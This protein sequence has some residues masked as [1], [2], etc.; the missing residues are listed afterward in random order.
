[1]ADRFEIRKLGLEHL[2]WA[3]AIISHS[4]IFHSPAWAEIY[5]ENKTERLYQTFAAAEYLV[6]HQIESGWSYGVFDREY[7]FKR[8]ASINDAAGGALYWDES[9]KTATGAQLLEQMDFPLVSIALALDAANPLDHTLLTSMEEALPF[10]MALMQCIEELDDGSKRAKSDVTGPRQVM[11]R[12]GTSTRADY[13]GLGVM[14]KAAHLLMREAAKA[15]FRAISIETLNDAVWHVWMNPPAP[16]RAVE[17]VRFR[18]SE[19]KDEK[20]VVLYPDVS[21]ITARV[22]VDLK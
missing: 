10:Y 14:K 4:N 18:V 3:R 1:M 17:V 9:N 6:R 11:L 22:Q 21:Q 8:P 12:N 2:D 7:Q 13:E 20:G 15:G 5:S 16:F 19:Y